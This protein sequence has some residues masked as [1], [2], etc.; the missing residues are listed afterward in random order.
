MHHL[1]S[2][3]ELRR[4]RLSNNFLYCITIISQYVSMLLPKNNSFLFF[5]GFA[6][7]ILSTER[8]SSRLRKLHKLI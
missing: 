5:N 7:L 3:A 2:V 6:S 1:K 4:S 8:H